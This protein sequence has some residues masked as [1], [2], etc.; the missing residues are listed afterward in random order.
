MQI[1]ESRCRKWFGENI[2]NV[3][4]RVDIGN[5]D[6]GAVD[7]LVNIMAVSIDM[8]HMHMEMRILCQGKS[9]LAICEQRGKMCLW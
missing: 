8:L 9:G 7:A 5:I 2:G 6:I 4:T 1:E 3:F